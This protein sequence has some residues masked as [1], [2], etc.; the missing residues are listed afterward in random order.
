M[1]EINSTILKF[2]SKEETRYIIIPWFLKKL[3]P[4][5]HDYLVK[6]QV[7]LLR[8]EVISVAYVTMPRW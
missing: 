2:F 1:K 3:S 6:Y 7:T 5:R 4:K 8:F